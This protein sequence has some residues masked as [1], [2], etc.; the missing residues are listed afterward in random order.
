MKKEFTLLSC[1]VILFGCGTRKSTEHSASQNPYEVVDNWPQF[2]DG[3]TLGQPT[4]IGIDSQDHVFVFHRAGRVWT[5]P[6]PDSAISKNTI[7]E[8]D[9]ESG[10]IINSWGANEFI[11][12]HGLNVDKDNNVWVTDVGLHQ[13]FKFSHDGQLLMKLGI[14]GEPGSDSLHFNLPTDVAISN[15]GT[16]YV[17]DGYGNS[18]VVKFSPNG[19]Y[20][21]EWGT[22]GNGQEQFDIPHAIAVDQKN[23]VY[24]A[25][26]QNNRIQV[27]DNAGKFLRIINND[28]NVDQL[29]SLT[30]DH[31]GKLFAV[32]YDA[33]DTTVIGSTIIAFDPNGKVLFHLGATGTAERTF[34]WFHDIAIDSKGNIY[35]GDIVGMKV[36]KYRITI[37]E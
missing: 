16:F 5:E 30:T 14:A 6:F 25:D 24:V 10:K 28:Q 37:D 17:S 1:L 23:T 34:S 21:K 36:V 9:N 3:F 33:A 19:K 8:L 27:F 31:S 2:P 11:M 22:H 35:V 18:R 29:P 13:I 15:N 4:G 32:D 20:I 7:M 12:P 26:R